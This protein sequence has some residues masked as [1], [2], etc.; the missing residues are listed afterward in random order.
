MQRRSA[1]PSGRTSGLPQAG[2]AAGNVHGAAPSG[3]S[4]SDGTDDLGD[5]VAGLAHD[6]RVAD[7]DVLGAHLVL[8]V[9]RRHADRRATDEHRVE[10]G[11]RR[12]PA[13]ATD[14]HL[15]V[16][17]QR[18]ALL[19]R[20]LVGDRPARRPRREAEAG[21]LLDVVDLDDDAVDLVVEIVAVLL[22]VLAVAEHVV[23]RRERLRLR[24][25]REAERA[26][27]RRATAVWLVSAG[28]PSTA[29]SWYD[30]K[31][32]VTLGRDRRRPS[33]AGCRPPSCAG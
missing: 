28:P 26:Q 4:A 29:P 21:P 1:S 27:V 31:D 7:A 12:R 18:R 13:G 17:Q 33:G 32:E 15:D 5:D 14:R 6:D 11:E 16:A 9:Q 19:R 23:E 10:H 3:R 24:V 20:E 25:D 22:P 8:V 30:Q 2:Q